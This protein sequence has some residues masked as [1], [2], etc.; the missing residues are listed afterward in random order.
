[1][2]ELKNNSNKFEFDHKLHKIKKFE[3]SLMFKNK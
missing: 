1:M 3:W 2:T